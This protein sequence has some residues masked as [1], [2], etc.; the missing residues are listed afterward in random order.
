[1]RKESVAP[2][3]AA[4]IKRAIQSFTRSTF[5]LSVVLLF[6]LGTATM[7]GQQPRIAV[8]V[9]DSSRSTVA[10]SHLILSGATDLG[11]LDDGQQFNRM[12]LVL[13]RPS[14]QQQALVALLDSQQTRGSANYHHWLAPEEFGKQFGPAPEDLKKIT[15]WL[16]QEGF[17]IGSVAK[18][19]M[20]IEFSGTVGQVNA[21]FH[22]QMRRYRVNGET[23][24][25]NASDISIPAALAPLVEGVPLH[26]FF[27]KPTLVR[28]QAQDSPAITAPWN[29]ANAITPGD[30]AAIYDLAPLY[31]SSLNGR[32]QT[33]AI[34]GEAD[35]APGD[36]TAFQQIFGLPANQPHVIENGADPGF[37]V[38]L[39]L[40]AE[41]TIDTEWAAAIAPGAT[42]DLV[43]TGP[44]STGDPAEL[45]AAYIVDENLAQIVSV[46]YGTCE[47]Y[48]GT[49]QT[50]LWNQVWEQAAAQGMS[51]FVASGDA[52]AAGCASAGDTYTNMNNVA[53]VSGLAS[54][55]YVTAVGGTEFDET[56]NGGSI[57]T[58]WNATNTANL[59]SAIGYIPEMVWNDS[60]PGS[61]WCPPNGSYEFSF[62]SAGGGGVSS[63]YATPSWQTLPVT[64]LSALESYTLPGQPGVFPRGVPDVSLAASADHDGYLFCFTTTASTPDCQLAGGA[65][66]QTTFQNEAGGT[67]FAAPAFA[68]IMAI[69]NQK[70]KSVITSPSPNPAGD[71]RQGLANYVLYPLAVSE[72]YSSCNSSNETTP[73]TPTPAACSFHDITVGN[74]SVPGYPAVTGYD[75]APGYDLASGLGSVDAANLVAN[76]TKAV[77]GFQG[78][79]TALATDPKESSI[80]IAHGQ[81]VTFNVGV[82][83]L[84]SDATTA[85]PTGNISL[86]A[87]G[88]TLP[89]SM[90][91]LA[92]VPLSGS[93]GAAATGDF[94]TGSLPGGTYNL[95]ARFAGDSTFAGSISNP[96]A[97]NI[98][99]EGS[100]TTLGAYG[101]AVSANGGLSW[102]S[103]GWSYGWSA[104]FSASVTG[105]TGQGVPSGVIT[106]LDN[107][108]VLAQVPLDNQ[109]M[110]YLNWCPPSGPTQ[111]FPNFSPLPCAAVGTHVYT[112]TYSGDTSF[113]ASPNPPAASQVANVQVSPGIT[114]GGISFNPTQS[115]PNYTL[116]EPLTLTTSPSTSRNAA[117][118]TGTI[119]FFLGTTAISQPILL[120][121]NP[122]QASIENVVLPQGADT[123][124]ANYSGDSNYASATY[125]SLM[126]WGVPVGWNATTT[127]A[128]VNPGQAATYNLS[129]SASGFS[130]VATLSCVS[131]MDLFNPTVTVPEAQCS[132]SPAS[133]NLTSGGAAV[134]VVV[135]ITT[136]AQSL[137][138]HPP[139][140]TLP[141]TLPPV[142]ALVFWRA[143]K[144]RWRTL[145]ACVLAALTISSV[146][147]CGGSGGGSGT[148][149]VGPPAT[150]GVFSVWAATPYSSTETVYNGAKLTL[151]VNQ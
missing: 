31:K 119:Q 75:A 131:S 106:F 111:I 120:S 26:D 77:A 22:T 145:L 79:Q 40:G 85:T 107:G 11:P 138:S 44:Q 96:V 82:Q 10:H 32:G 108:A 113:A 144:R 46:S 121:G 81:S 78:T 3:T 66:T 33:I 87:Q 18:S 54:S 27:S 140:H 147:S 136:T 41:A 68:G 13:R 129:L 128:T 48:L 60:C 36:L 124:T 9:D 35:I 115:D 90:G 126:Y 14:E 62:F 53:T 89:N 86:I 15:G 125:S 101:M 49:A 8:P 146:T 57:S 97:V 71:G 73:K 42:I 141:F 118:P 19:G 24:I 148:G 134:P 123:I 34:V 2:H 37:D 64:G 25:S 6:A 58:F 94:S 122:A 16:E 137:L 1:V 91:V 7:A 5:T 104:S 61:L 132:V 110:A 102:S 29:G 21:A 47:Q 150:S 143:R 88:G 74:N 84:T 43:V 114:Y 70:V 80:S 39:G 92:A 99:P 28:S 69:V 112:A 63:V 59:A 12:T 105:P 149:Y 117:A 93:G 23:H 95:V 151:N 83:R 65:V 17:S 51:V 98:T 127:V 130:G 100:T 45:S 116:S 38:F 20:R 67:S 103:T 4:F 139:F 109:G 72:Q 76:W 30:F 52:G 142:V 56:V 133:A 50:A 135:T 55:P